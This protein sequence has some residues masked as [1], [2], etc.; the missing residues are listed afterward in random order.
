MMRRFSL[1]TITVWLLSATSLAQTNPIP[2]PSPTAK[3][4]AGPLTFLSSD[5]MEGREA[6]TR[7]GFMAA[8]YIA[9]MM[10][11]NGL[12]PYG[13]F[14][15]H[16]P[17]QTC[18]L[19]DEK[20]LQKTYFQNFEMKLYY[21]EKAGSYTLILG[22]P[23]STVI[24]NVIGMIRGK[25]T[26]RSVVVG[27]HYDHLGIRGGEIYNG[28]DDNASGVC[29]MLAMAKKWS[30]R[31]EPPPCN[32]IFAAWTGEEKGRLGS[33]YFVRYTNANPIQIL[34]YINMDM[35]SRSAPEDTARKVISVGTLPAGERLRQIAIKSNHRLPHPFELD[36]WDVTGHTGS[37]YASFIAKNIPVMTFF[38]GFQ[39][40]YHTPGDDAG[41]VDLKKMED[42]LEVVNECLWQVLEQSQLR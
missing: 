26:T 29:G 21:T 38:S 20:I 25:D 3:D 16:K 28:A 42:I 30:G 9:S 37:D 35:I 27:A 15:T 6:G 19:A 13:D 12:A 2:V 7:G 5:W 31:E 32:I 39:A 18:K 24:S 23:G 22:K 14:D 1:S 4:F 17:G 34:A 41:K 10:Q 36:L 40:D 11:L 8:D 33:I